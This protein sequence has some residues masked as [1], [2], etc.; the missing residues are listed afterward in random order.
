MK[1]LLLSLL[2]KHGVVHL[3]ISSRDLAAPN[4]NVSSYVLKIRRF[5]HPVQILQSHQ[6]ICPQLVY[7]IVANDS[8]SRQ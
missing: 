4:E 6:G 8:F 3:Q 1:T 7:S 2:L 5:N